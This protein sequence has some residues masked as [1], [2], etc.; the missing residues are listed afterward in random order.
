MPPERDGPGPVLRAY[1]E[2]VGEDAGEV[3]RGLR[4]VIYAP[5]ADEAPA[6]TPAAH[7]GLHLDMLAEAVKRDALAA[8]LPMLDRR[9]REAVAGMRSEMRAA[10]LTVLKDTEDDDGGS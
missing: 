8:I 3:W 1:C 10:I 9:I 6:P 5:P 4:P 7:A 2:R